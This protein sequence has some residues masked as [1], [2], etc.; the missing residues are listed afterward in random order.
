M[1]TGITIPAILCLFCIGIIAIP[2][3]V[4]L[5]VPK[6]THIVNIYDMGTSSTF[7]NVNVV[8]TDPDTG[9]FMEKD[10]VPRGSFP[11]TANHSCQYG[12]SK[13]GYAN[14]TGTFALDYSPPYS[15]SIRLETGSG[16]EKR[17][18]SITTTAMVSGG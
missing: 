6:E 10:L 12:V 16:K 4:S 18:I 13:E 17:S 5:R 2:G 9:K 15:L 8:L 11:I 1:D 3:I 14:R 7:Q